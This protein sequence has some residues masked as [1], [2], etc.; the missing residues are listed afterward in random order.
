MGEEANSPDQMIL[1]FIWDLR[2]DGWVGDPKNSQIICKKLP[3]FGLGFLLGMV[4]FLLCDTI[5]HECLHN[6]MH[7]HQRDKT[8]LTFTPGN[9]RC[10]QVK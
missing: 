10:F 2:V 1:I 5:L 7:N 8:C 9:T 4:N 6:S 3:L